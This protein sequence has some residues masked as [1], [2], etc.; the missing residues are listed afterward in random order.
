[1]PTA[2]MNSLSAFASSREINDWRMKTEEAFGGIARV[3]LAASPLTS[4]PR[5]PGS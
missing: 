3:L 5:S 4:A 2:K 1:M